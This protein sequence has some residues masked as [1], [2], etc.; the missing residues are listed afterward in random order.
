MSRLTELKK[1]VG[2]RTLIM[3]VL[4]VTPDSFSDGGRFVET[5]SAIR[6]G[7]RLIAEGADIVDVGG[8]STRPGADPVSANEEVRRVTPVIEALAPHICISVDTMKASVAQAAIAAGASIVNDV[9]AL[10]GDPDMGRV[11]SDSGVDAVLMHMQGTPR[12]MQQS[13]HY[14]NVVDEVAVY[15]RERLAASKALDIPR[16]HLWIDPGIGFGKN[17]AHNLSLLRNLATFKKLGVPLVVGTSRKSFIG[18][19][20]GDLPPQDRLEGTAATVALAIA[21]GAD[22]VRVHD[23][24]AMKR[25]ALVADAV[26]REITDEAR[27]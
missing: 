24:K 16:D 21:A 22:V 5:E 20:L 19:L 23:V 27:E 7:L 12:T 4:N 25:V 14:D 9:T 11:V 10:T 13:P 26:L 2:I 6:Q 3:G 8:E 17:L 15:L 18:R 1:L